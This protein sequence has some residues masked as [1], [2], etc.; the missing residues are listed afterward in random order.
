MRLNIIIALIP[1]LGSTGCTT[2][3]AWRI[4]SGE[5]AGEV[6]GDSTQSRQSRSRQFLIGGLN[7]S[8]GDGRG[9]SLGVAFAGRPGL[10]GQSRKCARI[11]PA[12]MSLPHP[13]PQG[14]VGPAGRPAPGASFRF[15]PSACSA[16]KRP[17]TA[18]LPSRE[19]KTAGVRPHA[20]GF[21]EAVATSESS[22]PGNDARTDTGYRSACH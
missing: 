17:R 20:T 21:E 22:R 13:Q 5:G 19:S 14:I 10:F 16:K 15:L 6:P 18:H 7:S 8:R 2:P 12:R 11:S 4:F 1:K 3:Q 9:P